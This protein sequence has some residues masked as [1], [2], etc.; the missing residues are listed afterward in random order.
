[1]ADRESSVVRR[2]ALILSLCLLVSIGIPI[3]YATWYTAQF[4]RHA[5]QALTVITAQPVT[6]PANPAANPSREQ[7]YRLYEGLLSWKKSDGC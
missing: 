6:P 3:G 7:Y 4:A 2:W 1:M 5:C